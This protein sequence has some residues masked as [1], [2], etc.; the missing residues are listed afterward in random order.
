[1]YFDHIDAIAKLQHHIYPDCRVSFEND[2][3]DSKDA[4]A[5]LAV[6]SRLLE[7]RAPTF[8]PAKTGD[9]CRGVARKLRDDLAPSSRSGRGLTPRVP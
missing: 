5:I 6:V 4:D 7:S 8:R 3:A 2:K 9:A 1:M